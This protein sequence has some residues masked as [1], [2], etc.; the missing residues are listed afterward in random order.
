MATI[1]TLI[2]LDTDTLS[3]ETINGTS[4]GFLGNA[5][6]TPGTIVPDAVVTVNS[7]PDIEAINN[8]TSSNTGTATL[9]NVTLNGTLSG[10]GTIAINTFASP[11]LTGTTNLNGPVVSTSGY[12]LT[13]LGAG[14]GLQSQSLPNSQAVVNYVDNV[15]IPNAL[16][17]S[18]L[19]GAVTVNNTVYFRNNNDDNSIIDW[20]DSIIATRSLSTINYSTIYF[21]E[22]TNPTNLTLELQFTT[23]RTAS[24]EIDANEP[25][26]WLNNTPLLISGPSVSFG[27]RYLCSF[28]WDGTNYY[29]TWKR[30]TS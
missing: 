26:K 21:T 20:T 15:A 6:L 1:Q 17:D 9:N 12:I 13:S 5:S 7:G 25:I 8:L 24:V 16:D 3:G 22:P 30:F 27:T 23:S 2:P 28:Y 29:G 19:T 18:T 14:T 10:S 11:T 4:A